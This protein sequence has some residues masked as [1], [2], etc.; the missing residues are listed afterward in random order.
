MRADALSLKG[1]RKRLSF[2]LKL[3]RAG[4]LRP[5]SDIKFSIDA[6]ASEFYREGRYELSESR[7]NWQ[8]GRYDSIL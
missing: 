8:F 7:K 4:G 6:A 3:Q 1:Q 2:L 5:G